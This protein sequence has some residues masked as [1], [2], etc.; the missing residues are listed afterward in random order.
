MTTG[1]SSPLIQI[2]FAGKSIRD[3]RILWEDLSQFVSN[4]DSA[5]QRII[6]VLEKGTSIR[7]GRPTKA[8]QALTALEI[9]KVSA[10]SFVL[11]LNLRRDQDLL[12]GFDIGMEA[13]SQLTHGLDAVNHDKPLPEGIDRGVLTAL[14]E[15]GRIL[16][17]GIETITITP[18][19][20]I[21]IVGAEYVQRTRDQIIA[22]LQSLE[23]TWIE[24]EGR[25]L[26]ADVR[27]GSLRCRI[28]PSTGDWLYCRFAEEITAE[29]VLN[30]RHFVR[31]RGEATF[32]PATNK[33]RAFV[34]HDLEP[35][36]EPSQ[37]VAPIVPPSDFWDLRSF[38]DFAL[39]Q[40][41]YPLE[42]WQAISGGWPEGA[43][44]DSFLGAIRSARD[45]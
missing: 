44:F 10:G 42:D 36:E 24:I 17:R 39:E 26:M 4:L 6:N 35:I 31:A 21:S 13:V 1:L 14:R 29:V 45:E 32:D 11:G 2:S 16:D 33:I 41:V 30:M 3:G 40:G 25:L 5:I 19:R 15:A 27:E 28:H 7:I 20:E 23:Q 34:I 22:K 12:P 9:A 8:F 18:R 43:D 37:A 38:D